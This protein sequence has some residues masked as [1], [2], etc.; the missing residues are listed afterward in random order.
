MPNPNDFLPSAP[1]ELVKLLSKISRGKD[2]LRRLLTDPRMKHS[3]SLIENRCS[4]AQGYLKLW[5]EIFDT[6]RI[7]LT[8]EQPLT[9]EREDTMWKS[10]GQELPRAKMKNKYLKIAKD[11][12]ALATRVADSPLDRLAFDFFPHDR[13]QNFFTVKN[14]STLDYNARCEGIGETTH[15]WPS[16]T[17][18]LEELAR[19]AKTHAEMA[20]SEKRIADRETPDW[21]RNYFVRRLAYYFREKLGGP[22]Q[23]TLANIASVVFERQIS[24]KFVKQAL[25]HKII[26]SK[27]GA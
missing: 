16:M 7:S 12:E 17:D 8:R 4:S 20:M 14:W 18:L 22:M 24:Q 21:K 6:W 2:I 13:V 27:G 23:G 10:R 9:K 26:P 5:S 15:D 11:A 3:W 1:E 25:R 19:S